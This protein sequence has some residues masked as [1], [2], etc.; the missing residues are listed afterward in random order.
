MPIAD[1]L[2]MAHRPGLISLAGGL[3]APESFP[4]K[5][6]AAAAERL[7]ATQPQ[8]VLQYSTTEGY[9]PLCDWAA[10]RW[11]SS[12]SAVIVTAGSQQALEL[13][14]RS[15]IRPGDAVAMADPGYIGA[16]EAARLCRARLIG[17]PS[18]EEG[19]QVDVLAD[20]LRRGAS[21]AAVYVVSNFDNP[22]GRTLS[23]E[24]RSALAEL[25]EKHGFVIADDD[26]YGD[27]RWSGAALPELISM[28]SRVAAMRSMS[29]ILA[30]GLRVGFLVAD[31]ALA[32]DVCRFKQA[33]DVHTS[34]LSQ[35]LCLEVVSASGFLDRH[36]ARLIDLYRGKAATL[37]DALGAA[38]KDLQFEMPGGGMFLWGRLEDTSVSAT[39][40]L[41]AA[42]DYGVAFVPGSAFSVTHPHENE[43]RLSYATADSAD[44][45]EAA[46][47][48][49][50]ALATLRNA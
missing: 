39:T 25:A 21:L 5:E 46:S 2:R 44:L 49:G 35:R 8:D 33:T 50:A 3:P 43:L 18:D 41:S 6:M 16:I 20:V 1:V 40:L 22:T 42:V 15:V 31:S 32:A 29:K 19:M 34:T 47:R 30:P 17:I 37:A 36:I 7:I 38:V 48:L 28:S 12:G 4:S 13:V 24:R 45:V 26:P 9:G 23:L 27:L 10:A 11:A 14:F